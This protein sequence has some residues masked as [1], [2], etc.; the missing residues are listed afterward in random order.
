[1]PRVLPSA[2]ALFIELD[3][4]TVLIEH[5]TEIIHNLYALMIQNH[6]YYGDQT[7]NAMVIVVY[8]SLPCQTYHLAP[9]FSFSGPTPL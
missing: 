5:I 4:N 3:P 9:L 8:I 6:T 1:M 7:A 2:V